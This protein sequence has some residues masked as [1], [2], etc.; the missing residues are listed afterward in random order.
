MARQVWGALRGMETFAQLVHQDD[1]TGRVSSH[2]AS[3][4]LHYHHA[5]LA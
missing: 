4:L 1:D 3:L 5:I 2:Y